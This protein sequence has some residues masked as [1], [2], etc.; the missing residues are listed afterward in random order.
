MTE[1]VIV[2]KFR[3]KYLGIVP[4]TGVLINMRA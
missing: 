1:S 4:F 2:D 3:G